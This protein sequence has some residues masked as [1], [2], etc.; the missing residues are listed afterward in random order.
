MS[1]SDPA[2]QLL[3]KGAWLLRFIGGKAP[4]ATRDTNEVAHA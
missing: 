4:P 3:K 2:V 1:V